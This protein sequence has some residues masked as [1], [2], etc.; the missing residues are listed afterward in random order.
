MGFTL[1]FFT[2]VPMALQHLFP[3]F[4]PEDARNSWK[5]RT[6]HAMLLCQNLHH[7]LELGRIW[8]L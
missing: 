8:T 7:H 4:S 6:F 1:V 2:S 5:L 3:E